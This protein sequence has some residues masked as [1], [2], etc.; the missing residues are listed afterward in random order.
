MLNERSLHSD[1]CGFVG[2]SGSLQALA[3][4]LDGAFLDIALSFDAEV[5]EFLP[6][7]PVDDLRKI[8]YFTSFPHLV[9]F[10]VSVENESA[11]LHEF[12]RANGAGCD[13]PLRLNRVRAV[14]AVL[15]PAACY[16]VYIALKG[17]SLETPRRITV[18]G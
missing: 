4:A 16:A 5:Q 7:L 12:A 9:T 2:L 15:A 11:D 3:G 6:L 14:S 1:E 13:G 17:A 18:K 8:D 10:P